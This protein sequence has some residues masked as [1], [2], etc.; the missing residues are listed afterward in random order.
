MAIVDG[1]SRSLP[2]LSYSVSNFHDRCEDDELVPEFVRRE[3]GGLQGSSD[4]N[5]LESGEK[6][7]QL[8][9]FFVVP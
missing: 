1:L 6:L 2:W 5:L 3:P 7:I 9:G 4:L 8:S